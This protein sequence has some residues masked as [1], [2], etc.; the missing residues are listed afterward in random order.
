MKKPVFKK[1]ITKKKP[2]DYLEMAKRAR[3][4]YENLKK[5]TEE[6]KQEFVKFAHAGLIQEFL[7]VLNNFEEALTH[8]PKEDTE[9][10]WVTGITYIKKQFEEVLKAHGAE[11][12]G[13]KGDEFN[14]ELHEAVK[15]VKGK[16]PNKIVKIVRQ[17][18]KIDTKVIRPAHV[19]VSK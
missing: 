9:S 3:A 4:D 19:I 18:C 7:P 2:E 17:G 15:E 14:P 5:E 6:W 11:L 1:T 12:Y 16:E 10:G 13:K 8:V